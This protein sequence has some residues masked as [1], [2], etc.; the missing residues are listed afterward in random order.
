MKFAVQTKKKGRADPSLAAELTAAWRN[1][2]LR[3][4]LLAMS[5]RVLAT[6]A[7]VEVERFILQTIER[8]KGELEL[9]LRHP[10]RGPAAARLLGWASSLVEQVRVARNGPLGDSQLRALASWRGPVNEESQP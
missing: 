5:R 2:P 9:E 4:E 1:R 6:E 10:A 8:A 7:T 3:D